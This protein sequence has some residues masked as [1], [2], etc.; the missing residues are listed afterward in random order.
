MIRDSSRHRNSNKKKLYEV[1]C[2][3]DIFVFFSLSNFIRLTISF[4]GFEW[5]I[6]QEFKVIAS[7]LSI[8]MFI[9]WFLLKVF[10]HFFHY[11]P[12]C[13]DNNKS[14][15]DSLHLFVIQLVCSVAASDVLAVNEVVM[16]KPLRK[17]SACK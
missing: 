12:F 6:K 15:R 13:I 4:D 2:T 14:V 10:E 16:M 7:A 5:M 17:L 1:F 8:W 9:F 11:F 3:K